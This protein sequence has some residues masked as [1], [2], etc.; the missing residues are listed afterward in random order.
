MLPALVS[1][2]LAGGSADIELLPS[3]AA[4]VVPGV[5][6]NPTG[7]GGIIRAN[8]GLQYE[9]DPLVASEEDVEFGSVV[10]HRVGGWF[11]AQF[12]A[13]RR[14]SL[15]IAIPLAGNFGS[16]VSYLSGDGFGLADPS[17]GVNVGFLQK[18]SVDL[19]MRVAL[20]APIGTKEMWL[21]DAGVRGSVSLNGRVGETVVAGWSLGA[22]IRDNSAAGEYLAVGTEV[23]G[24][25]GVRV[26]AGNVE[27]LVYVATRAGFRGVVDGSPTFSIEPGAGARINVGEQWAIMGTVGRGVTKGYGAPDFRG[28]VTLTWRKPPAPE[29]IA[30]VEV[31][32]IPDPPEDIPD[33]VFEPDPEPEPPPPPPPRVT[34]DQK[35]R[36]E[37]ND[38]TIPDAMRVKIDEVAAALLVNP[39]I[40][41][42]VIEGRASD[43][44]GFEYN[45]ELSERRAKAVF[46]ALLRKGIHPDRLSYRAMGEVRATGEGVADDRV[47]TFEVTRY[48]D[49]P[50]ERSPVALPWSGEQR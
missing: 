1:L 27:P 15:D 45:Y 13:S 25:L 31:V 47:V 34:I 46:E 35:V 14:V 26:P 38:D 5:P 18:E 11:A 41:H 10:K 8:V 43:E 29:E 37:L 17:I 24:N 3:L 42:V 30:I 44:A 16:E 9:L 7:E 20:M 50:A 6:E 22:N 33:I 48:T 39:T 21:G 19:G 12:T 49:A 40:D 23:F 2:A 4:E 28:R 36:F 32:D